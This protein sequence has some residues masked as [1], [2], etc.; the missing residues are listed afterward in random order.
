M[1]GARLDDARDASGD[2]AFV[3]KG[4]VAVELRLPGT[5]RAT[6]DID[7]IVR[8][9]GDLVGA[10]REA[11]TGEH[12]GFAFRVRGETRPMPGSSVRVAVALT[13]RG[14][15]W[16][17]IQ[18]DLSPAEGERTE[19]ERL[20]P[21]D[22]GWFGLDT[23]ASL[24]CL[25]LRYQIA[26]K[27]HAMTEPAPRDAPANERFRDLVDLLVL[28][29]LAPDL[30]PLREACE[31]VFAIRGTHQWPPRLEPP[32]V[33]REPFARLAAQAGIDAPDLDRAAEVIRDWIRAIAVA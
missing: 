29:A 10:L 5:A 1:L 25:S 9:G 2:A 19:I 17:T 24:P 18:V 13:Y 11:L 31:E 30:R 14:R 21:L 15:A 16:G 33:W 32:E 23:P 20:D 6:R 12:Q 28:R 4:A 27:F 8:N 26:Q 22:L 3:I 7:L